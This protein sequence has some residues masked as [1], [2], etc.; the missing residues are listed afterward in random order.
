MN[1]RI[2]GLKII[3]KK[4][5]LENTEKIMRK[6]FYCAQEPTI[7]LLGTKLNDDRI[8]EHMYN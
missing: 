1:K 3:L 5:I 4:K 8:V 2:K 6:Y 7:N